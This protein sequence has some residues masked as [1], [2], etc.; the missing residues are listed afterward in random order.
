MTMRTRAGLIAGLVLV[1]AACG[2]GS[3]GEGGGTVTNPTGGTTTPGGTVPGLADQ[4]PLGGLDE[5]E[6]A[7][8]PVEITYWHAMTRANEEA[9]VALTDEF[10]A[11]QDQVRVDL[12]NQNAYDDNFTKF[13]TAFGTDDSPDLIQLEDTA[14]QRLVDA[15][16]VVPAQACLDAAGETTEDFVERVSS[17]YS[18]GGV[19]YPMPFN[20]SNPVFYYNKVAFEQAGLD[21]EVAPTTFAEVREF[22]EQI[23]AVGYDYGFAFKRDPWVLEQFL[24][25]AGEPYVNNDNGRAA[26]ATEVAFDTPTASSVFEWLQSGVD[27]G[28]FTSNAAGGPSGFDNLISICN[29]ANAMTIDT[30][31]ALGTATQVLESEGCQVEVEVGVAPLPLPSEDLAGKGGVLVGGA[32]NY[33][34]ANGDP[35]RLA[36]AYRFAA[37]LAQ[38]EQQAK[39]AAATGYIPVRI[40]SG[41]SQVMRDLW[42]D[43]P[44]Y[45]VAFDQLQSGANNVAT[46]GPVIGDYKG[47]R[48]ALTDALEALLVEGKDPDEVM[49]SAVEAANARIR[50]YNATV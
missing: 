38:P 13:E 7:A 31:A 41:E 47:V 26:R 27:A 30:S 43:S 46:A 6:A 37:F 34:P 22:A 8:G 50:D 3:G 39:W 1:A 12:V 4:C 14:L 24:S 48:D 25:L 40:S 5:R 29:G 18:L 10:N 42:A 49:R 11:A 36:A 19:L 15:E 9:L 2:G 45:K 28:V 35:V 20:V 32:A 23:K 21:P 17:Y 44:G 33:L 16:A